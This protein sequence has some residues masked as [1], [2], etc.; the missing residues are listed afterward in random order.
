MESIIIVLEALGVVF[1]AIAGFRQGILKPYFDHREEER[2]WKER[3]ERVKEE[4]EQERSKLLSNKYD[5]LSHSISS[6]SNL[7]DKLGAEQR[8]MLVD[9]AHFKERF[10]S[11][12]SRIELIQ[13]KI[14]RLC[15]T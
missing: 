8:Q 15:N 2:K 4:R 13:D 5:Q 10:H 1:T 11:L 7:V 14:E 6:L 3:F 12:E 9:E